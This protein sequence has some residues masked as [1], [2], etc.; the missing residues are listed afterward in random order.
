MMSDFKSLFKCPGCEGVFF[1]AIEGGILVC[2]NRKDKEIGCGWK[3]KSDLVN[4]N[5]VAVN[6]NSDTQSV[7]EI[8]KREGMELREEGY[9][10]ADEIPYSLKPRLSHEDV[11][12]WVRQLLRNLAPQGCIQEE[13]HWDSHTKFDWHTVNVKHGPFEAQRKLKFY[14]IK[15]KDGKK[16]PEVEPKIEY[17]GDLNEDIKPKEVELGPTG[18]PFLEN[19]DQ[20]QSP[21]E[22]LIARGKTCDPMPSIDYHREVVADRLRLAKIVEAQAKAIRIMREHDDFYGGK[23]LQAEINI[24]MEGE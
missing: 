2:A 17:D 4:Q 23:H 3:G 5:G 13:Y 7:T 15:L 11:E 21:V 1:T 18:I 19:H 9:C 14:R 16:M 20:P 24:I 8:Y 12:E 6:Q 22:K 10:C